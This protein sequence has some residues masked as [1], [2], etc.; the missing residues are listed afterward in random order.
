MIRIGVIAA[1]VL[2]GVIANFFSGKSSGD[3]AYWTEAVKLD[4][5]LEKQIFTD[6]SSL[7]S[8]VQALPIRSVTDP[9]LRKFH[10]DFIDLLSSIESGAE[11]QVIERKQNKLR[12]LIDELNAKYAW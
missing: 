3:K 9:R 1:I 11:E 6:I 12:K 2:I 7:K 4:R 8:Q 5:S 10:F